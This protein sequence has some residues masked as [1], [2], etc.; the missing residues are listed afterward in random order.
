VVFVENKKVRK[1]NCAGHGGEE[2]MKTALVI[3]DLR[4]CSETTGKVEVKK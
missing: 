4:K 2:E 3:D 1:E